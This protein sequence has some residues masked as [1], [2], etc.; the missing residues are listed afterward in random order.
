MWLVGTIL[1][2]TEEIITQIIFLNSISSNEDSQLR[3]TRNRELVGVKFMLFHI[4][5]GNLG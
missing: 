2:R 5:E 4:R 3:K 1:V